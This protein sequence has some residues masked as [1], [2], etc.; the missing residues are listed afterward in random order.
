MELEHLVVH[1]APRSPILSSV[2]WAN[3]PLLCAF[4]ATLQGGNPEHHFGDAEHNAMPHERRCANDKAPS[5]GAH[6]LTSPDRSPEYYVDHPM[7]GASR[8]QAGQAGQEAAAIEC[9]P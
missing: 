2:V 1:K 6:G 4:S 8:L 3:A 9:K 5:K 7:E